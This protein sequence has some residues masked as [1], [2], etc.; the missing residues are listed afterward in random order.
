[1]VVVKVRAMIKELNEDGWFQVR[2][3][4]S[5]R[6]FRHGEKSGSVTVP[7]ALG[8]ELS[9]PTVASIVRQAGLDRR[10]R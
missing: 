5:H 4:G 7:G 8:I 9:K 1:L 2:Q 6:I 10:P 3:T